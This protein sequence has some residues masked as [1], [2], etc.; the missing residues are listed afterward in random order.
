M[1]RAAVLGAPVGHSLS[2]VLHRAAYAALGLAD[3]TYEAVECDE[4]RL[5][6][7]LAGL[8]DSWAGLSLTMPLKRTVLPMLDEVSDLALAVGG[9]NT[10]VLRGG[11]RLGHNTDVHGIVTA[12][13]EAGLIR[14]DGTPGRVLIMGGGATACSALAALRELGAAEATVAVR[15]TARAAEAVAAAGRLGMTV[16]VR[17]LGELDRLPSADLVISTLPAGAADPYAAL[18][19]KSGAA[20]FDVVY[21]PWP[22]RLAVAVTARGGAVVGGF[23]MLLHQAVRQVELMTGRADVPVEAMRA[24][25]TAEIARRQRG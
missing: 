12:L 2:P 22:T 18:I 15:E 20:V 19:A 8:D 24:A 17:T 23:P 9:A 3:W 14:P 6:S 11:R 13:A 25:G 4:A 21:A 1:R 7:L 5:A 16:A 10:V